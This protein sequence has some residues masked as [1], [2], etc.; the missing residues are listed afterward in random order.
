MIATARSRRHPQFILSVCILLAGAGAEEQE[1]SSVEDA[2]IEQNRAISGKLDS[3]ADKIDV[4]FA[5]DR[6]TR[7]KNKTQLT[8]HSPLLWR[9]GGE[10]D[11]SPHFGLRLH[12]PNVQERFRLSF[13]SYDED[14]TDVG[15][16]KKLYREPA[17]ER[18]YGTSVQFMQ[19]LGS[20]RTTFRPRVEFRDK[21]LTSYLVSFASTVDHSFWSFEPELQLFARSDVGTG[22]FLS[23]NTTFLLDRAN[24]LRIINEEQYTDGNNTLTTN[25]GIEIKHLYNDRM[26]Q[27]YT[28]LVQANNRATLHNELLILRSSFHHKLRPEI[29]HYSLTPV[30]NFPKERRFRPRTELS[31]GLSVIF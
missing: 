30:V 7:K 25:H 4:F 6:M 19:E 24:A 13:T 9:E 15:T 16:N 5:E 29:L 1:R 2:L 18:N 26:E 21:L 17:G 23:L 31:L 28:L 14:E 20:V 11:Y 10:V 22:Q 12:L 27:L 3:Y 8:L